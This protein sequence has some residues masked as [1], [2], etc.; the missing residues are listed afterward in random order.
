ME[1]LLKRI[2]VARIGSHFITKFIW[3]EKVKVIMDLLVAVAKD[4]LTT[5]RLLIFLGERGVALN[6]V[7]ILMEGL[8]MRAAVK[9]FVV[10]RGVLK[11]G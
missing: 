11:G 9:R 8:P 6:T 5:G 1:S 7:S 10:W 2:G 4:I 3:W